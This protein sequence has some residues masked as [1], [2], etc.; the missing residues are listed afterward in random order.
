ML[1]VQLHVDIPPT[2]CAQSN[3]HI[4]FSYREHVSTCH[5]SALSLLL[6]RSRTL[7]AEVAPSIRTWWTRTPQCLMM[8]LL[9]P[10]PYKTSTS[11]SW[12]VLAMSLRSLRTCLATK[13][14]RI[15]RLRIW[16]PATEAL[17]KEH[18]TDLP[19]T[20]D[21]L[22]EPRGVRGFAKAVVQGNSVHAGLTAPQHNCG[23]CL[24]LTVPILVVEVGGEQGRLPC[25]L[26]LP[27]L[28]A[29]RAVH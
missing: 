17:C 27:M 5:D 14:G 4:A 28:F 2:K 1:E 6:Y 25:C 10:S 8:S 22:D 15:A 21:G 29:T 18:T 26:W 19:D 7:V 9:L 3:Q 12:L 16:P 13:R 11:A 23:P 24:L 20:E